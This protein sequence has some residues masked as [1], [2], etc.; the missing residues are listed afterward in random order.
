[1]SETETEARRA[2]EGDANVAQHVAG[3]PIKKF[4]YV[5]GKIVNLLVR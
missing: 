4:L 3:K 2:A 1:M 5:P